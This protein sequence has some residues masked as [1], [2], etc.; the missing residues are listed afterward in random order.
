MDQK[1]DLIDCPRCGRK[2]VYLEKDEVD[3]GVGIIEHLIGCECP[4]CGLIAM[5]S[6]C[7]V[8]EDKD[9]TYPHKMWCEELKNG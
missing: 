3:C 6:C 1:P 5:S 9:G 7:G 4:H 8:W 2:D